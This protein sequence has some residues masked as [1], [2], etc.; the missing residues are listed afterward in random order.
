MGIMTAVLAELYV[1]KGRETGKALELSPG[2]SVSFGRALS[3]DVRIRDAQ[4]S[5][6]HC[7]FECTEQGLSL[8][9]MSGNG[10]FVNADRIK[11][12]LVP[13]KDG[14]TVRLGSTEIRVLIETEEEARARSES[15][16]ARPS[17][18]PAESIVSE[19]TVEDVVKPG[20]P[21]ARTLG[22]P[23][24]T[25]AELN[26]LK[27]TRARRADTPPPA[28]AA[29]ATVAP[30]PETR[31]PPTTT[32]LAV[33]EESEEAGSTVGLLPALPPEP[34]E[35]K[36]AGPDSPP[37]AHE[38]G[39]LR[40]VIPGYRIEAK[41][42]GGGRRGTVV[43]RALQLAL[44]RPVALKVLLPGA[45]ASEKD[46][47][48]FLREAASIARLPHPNV[49]T[50]HDAGRAGERRY[51][52]ME[53]LTGGSLSDLLEDQQSLPLDETL[54]LASDVGRALAF[55]HAR[56]IVHRS[57]R[58]VNVLRDAHATWKLV[59]FGLAKDV[60]RGGGG[61]TNYIDAPLEAIAYLAPE[62]VKQGGAVDA[63]SDVYSAGALLY[64]ALTGKPPFWGDS[65][66]TIAA[67]IGGEPPLEPLLDK[68]P[69]AL[70]N[71]VK[72]CLSQD[73]GAR[74]EDGQTFLKELAAAQPSGIRTG[75][76]PRGVR[77]T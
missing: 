44:D 54:L 68:A 27:K 36:T 20:S 8:K 59:D 39:H 35:K 30:A 38:A 51:I 1:I 41:L 32:D 40:E 45:A 73:P 48:R 33:D 55:A 49:V 75:S 17:E 12:A 50:I 63:R 15:V 69:G 9:D 18:A 60:M 66:A 62:Q 25:L 10:T 5:R 22:Q 34:E 57:I 31:V 70:A 13:L 26:E 4:V 72:K 56:G 42:G 16:A 58:P 64:H 14:D 76:R 74:Y 43:Y 6:C 67:Q 23:K 46:L 2:S 21:Q 53:L 61:E 47:G 7:R 24:I 11:G 3:N 28:P 77:A 52:V 37:A 65:V 29:A 71:V 19:S